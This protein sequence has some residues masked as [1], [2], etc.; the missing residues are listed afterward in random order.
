MRPPVHRLSARRIGCRNA[1][2]L[3]TVRALGLTES[4]PRTE[5]VPAASV[6]AATSFVWGVRSSTYAGVAA[7]LEAP[8]LCGFEPMNKKTFADWLI[9]A[10]AESQL[11]F[12]S[13]HLDE[14]EITGALQ[15]RGVE[16]VRDCCA[17]LE[18]GKALLAKHAGGHRIRYLLA[19]LPLGASDHL[20]LWDESLWRAVGVQDEPVT[21]YAISREQVLE[22][23][24]E[25]YRRP[26]DV[27]LQEPLDVLALYRCWRTRAD[28]RNSWEFERG[29]YLVLDLRATAEHRGSSETD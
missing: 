8:A 7:F 24:D 12:E 1:V 15:S 3:T 4:W 14:L 5:S 9:A 25:E 19:F 16:L 2:R 11:G 27:P 22:E 20:C 6:S 23:W 29:L 17:L 28:M 10:T 26:V 13:A 21:L 18:E